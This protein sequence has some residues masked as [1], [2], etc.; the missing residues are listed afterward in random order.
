[1]VFGF[2]EGEVESMEQQNVQNSENHARRQESQEH[3]DREN[4]LELKRDLD[5]LHQRVAVLA[6]RL[7][8]TIASE[9]ESA[10]RPGVEP[11]MDI[12]ENEQEFLI[13]AALPGVSPHAIRIETTAHTVTLFAESPFV[14][15]PAPIAEASPPKRHRRSRYAGQ[16]RY[17]F[18][19]T[20][21]TA[22]SPEAAGA[23]FRHGMVE[24][25]LPKVRSIPRAV[26]IPLRMAEE[27]M[28][29]HAVT[30]ST[31]ISPPYELPSV[32]PLPVHPR[33]GNPSNKMG[34]AYVPSA[35]EDHTA[36]AQS[37]GES[38]Q[39]RIHR[40]TSPPRIVPTEQEIL[41]DPAAMEARAAGDKL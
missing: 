2:A 26:N 23:Q 19:Y 33:E 27:G 16:E 1:M 34:M 4:L 18:V 25:H 8:E 31:Q 37:I 12:Y 7:S 13:H 21:Y 41:D 14:Q 11:E 35:G 17:H 15:Q 30:S 9:S 20:L 38:S 36:K 39:P 22:I 29:S 10:D 3:G 24:I 32:S 28:H 6:A 40:V 5:D